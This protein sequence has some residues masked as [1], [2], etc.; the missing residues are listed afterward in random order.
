MCH[1]DTLDVQTCWSNKPSIV[2]WHQKPPLDK[3]DTVKENK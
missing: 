1:L 3:E 2:T